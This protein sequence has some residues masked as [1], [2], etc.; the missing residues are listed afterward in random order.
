MH[1]GDVIG[2]AHFLQVVEDGEFGRGRLI[3]LPAQ[4]NALEIHAQAL[5]LGI[6]VAPGPIFSATRG[7][8]HCLRLNYGHAWDGHAEK[9]MQTLG[10]LVAAAAADGPAREKIVA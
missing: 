10:R 9:A 7:F 5:K 4:V 6:S 3:E 2:D 1:E 8:A